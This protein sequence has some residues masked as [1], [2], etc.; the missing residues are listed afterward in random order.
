MIKN[1]HDGIKDKGILTLA[2]LSEENQIVMT[3]WAQ[4]IFG[5]YKSVLEKHLTKIKHTAKLPS[6]EQDIKMA[7]KIL[8]TAYSVSTTQFGYNYRFLSE[9]DLAEQ[10]PGWKRT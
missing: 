8:L 2:Q 4:D 6:S 7:I 1:F 9:K 3:K 5:L 10:C